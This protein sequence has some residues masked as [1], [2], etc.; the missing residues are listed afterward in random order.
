MKSKGLDGVLL[1]D[2]DPGPT[3]HDV[4][5][6]CRRVLGEKRI[7]H[8]GTLDPIA[9]GLLPLTVGHATRLTRFFMMDRKSYQGVMRLGYST[10]TYD[11]TGKRTS[12]DAVAVP[13]PDEV[14]EAGAVFSG[15]IKHQTPPYSARKVGGKKL[16]ELARR[17]EMVETETK[18]VE[19][20]VFQINRVEGSVVEFHVD[21]STGTYVRSLAHELGQKLGCGAHLES[22][23]RLRVGEFSVENAV[24]MHQLQRMR[25]EGRAGEAIL[26]MS[27]LLASF[28]A[29]A[30]TGP[31]V[32]EITHGK[33][34]LRKLDLRAGAR[35]VK[36]LDPSGSLTAIGEIV[37]RHSTIITIHPS[38]VLAR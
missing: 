17:G 21:C 31:E 23:R 9:G 28:D 27:G 19:I 38:V 24:T 8:L 16:Y 26:P 20:Y 35:Y 34:L 2:K 13:G 37:S 3:S 5:A 32:G 29:I 6:A 1:M 4:V 33:D 25:A 30:L 15:R 18:E 10:D 14:R 22:L 7:G 36:L 12:D 11:R